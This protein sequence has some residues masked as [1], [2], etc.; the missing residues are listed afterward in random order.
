MI[1]MMIT[2]MIMLL[3][4]IMFLYN[5]WHQKDKCENKKINSK[6]HYRH[7]QCPKP[8]LTLEQL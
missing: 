2:M 5:I 6:P 7:D 4:M 3:F 1:T 8:I